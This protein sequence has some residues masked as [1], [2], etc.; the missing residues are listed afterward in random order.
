MFQKHTIYNG[1][2][3]IYTVLFLK[4]QTSFYG[5]RHRHKPFHLS[6]STPV[7]QKVSRQTWNSLRL[8]MIFATKNS[9][10]QILENKPPFLKFKKRNSL[11][12]HS[13]TLLPCSEKDNR[14]MTPHMD[15]AKHF[16]GLCFTVGFFFENLKNKTPFIVSAGTPLFLDRV[17]KAPFSHG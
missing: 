6:P 1:I 10:S 11:C 2:S 16:L 17:Q 7:M 3:M 15:E 14:C 5:W 9:F 12:Q 8:S 13:P 4:K